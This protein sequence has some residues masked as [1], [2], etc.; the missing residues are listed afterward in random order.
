[1]F[2]KNNVQKNFKKQMNEI[3]K[4]LKSKEKQDEGVLSNN[5]FKLRFYGYT[6]D[7]RKV[8]FGGMFSGGIFSIIGIIFA[9]RIIMSI[10][11]F[12]IYQPYSHS[13]MVNSYYEGDY[14]QTLIYSD[15]VLKKDH[16]DY[17]ALLFKAKSLRALEK[18]DEAIECLKALE[19]TGL[20]S[21]PEVLRE[22]GNCYADLEKHDDAINYYERVLEIDSYD[23]IVA[24]A[25]GWEYYY[26][27]EYEKASQLAQKAFILNNENRDAKRLINELEKVSPEVKKDTSLNK[28][29]I[30]T[31]NK[32]SGFI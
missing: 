17:N 7:S 1:M 30:Q 5:L 24:A 23:S 19:S 27:G 18:Y 22:Y 12:F 29:Q 20:E 14:S 21:D 32:N 4:E 10:A 26:I 13:D 28:E 15:K 3:E 8:R 31:S 9:I 16:Y 11:S 2:G 25:L 6:H